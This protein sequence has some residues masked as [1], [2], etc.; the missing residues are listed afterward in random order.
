MM[1]TLAKRVWRSRDRIRGTCV[2]SAS[3][4]MGAA[5]LAHAASLPSA[6]S[7]SLRES[8]IPADSVAVVVQEIGASTP[9]VS[10][11]ADAAMNPASVMKLVTTFTALEALGPAFTWKTD[12]FVELSSR[13]PSP[14]VSMSRPRRRVQR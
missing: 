12:A 3:A 7:L 10:H 6:F 2:L 4:M 14:Q 11:R 9:L 5:V 8:A 1:R 13:M